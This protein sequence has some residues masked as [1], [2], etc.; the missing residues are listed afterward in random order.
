MISCLIKGGRVIDPARQLDQ[1]ADIWIDQ[2]RIKAVE[3]NLSPPEAPQ[4]L[5]A[6]G[7][8]VLPG[9]IDMHVHLREPGQEHKEDLQ[10]GL[11]AAV[12]GGFT[13]VLAMPNT[14]P[15]LDSA[16]LI[17][18]LLARAQE[19]AG[20][21][22]CLAATMT[23]G[24]QGKELSEYQDLRAAGAKA[25]TDDGSWVADSQVMRRILDYAQV[26]GLLPLSHAQ[27]PILAAGGAII[28]G[29]MS[30]RLG[31]PGIPAQAEEIAI[32]RDLALVELTGQPLHICHVSTQQ[33]VGL[34]RAA[35]AKGLP[36]SAETAPH[37]LFLTEEAV[38]EYNSAAK[39][40]PPLGTKADREALREALKD[41][42]I[43]VIA[44]DHAPHSILDK[45]VEF[46]DAA[47]G[48][49][50]LE[51]SLPLALE[52]AREIDLPIP[53]LVELMSRNPARLLGLPGGS[54]APG[55]PADITIVDPELE[56]IYEA[57]KGFSKGLNT[58][59]EGRK[60]RGRAVL[61]LVGG[62]IRY[63]WPNLT[64]QSQACL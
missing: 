1:V 30:A 49:T 61:T 56:F 55:G 6:Q 45:E 5:D 2:G 42:T 51:T 11:T 62:E 48:I 17:T 38:G 33:G 12:A 52:L 36:V 20:A 40:N 58:P 39:M 8:W 15:P 31:L 29:R 23:R 21:R 46:I 63:R 22:L 50:G 44:T 34:I 41:G 10:S 19:I 16:P 35:R 57:K 26:F 18:G 13:T 9:L 14:S 4:A 27:D 54:L 60:F 32:F 64:R 7:L 3:P 28:E 37:Y 53:R 59:F 24:R 47:F 43:S 25:V